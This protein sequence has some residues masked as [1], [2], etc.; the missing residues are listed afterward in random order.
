MVTAER[1]T[2]GGVEG[3][4][5]DP[6]AP[7]LEVEDLHVEFRTRAGLVKAND[8]V[9]YRLDKG[10]TLAIVGESG[11]GKTVS[12]QAVMGIIDTPPGYVT[13]GA[14]RF[15]GVDLFQLPEGERRLFRGQKIAMIFQDALTALNP[16]FRVGWQIGEMYRQHRGTSKAEA[17]KKAIELLERVRIPGARERVDAYPH[18]FSGGMRQRAMIAM[19]LALDP[20][21]LIA[22]EPTT[23]LDV[24]VQAQIMKLLSDLQSETGMGL[25]LITH[26]LAV[27][28]EVTDRAAVMYAGR[29]VEEGTTRQV[30]KSPRHPY[31]L[32]LMSS[33]ATPEQKG[34]KLIPIPGSPPDLLHIPPGCPFHPRCPFAQEICVEERPPLRPLGDG[35]ASACHFAGEVVGLGG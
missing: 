1:Q 8:G 5:F 34:K 13:R 35:R 6:N 29:I 30:F 21:V 7:L 18:E 24:T 28:A 17:R 12:A 32:G 4:D 16:V 15:R 9:S 31:T 2:R 10:E 11:S 20:E 33:I 23:A 26:D 25:I 19:A 3:V 14:A 27:V 22:D